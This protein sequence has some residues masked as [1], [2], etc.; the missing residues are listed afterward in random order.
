MACLHYVTFN[1]KPEDELAE[2]GW[3]GHKPNLDSREKHVVEIM[4]SLPL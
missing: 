2:A 1:N 4:K 3:T